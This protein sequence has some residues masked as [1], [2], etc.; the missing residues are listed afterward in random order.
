MNIATHSDVSADGVVNNRTGQLVAVLLTA[1]SDAAQIILYDNA[2]AASGTVL[3]NL[4]ALT[5]ESATFCPAV[6]INCR[7]GIY[8]D[9][10]GTLANATVVYI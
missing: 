5:G 10:S 6:P 1:G 2:S 3:A 4:K 8:A 9:I 7:A